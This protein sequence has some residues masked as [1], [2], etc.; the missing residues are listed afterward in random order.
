MITQR[1][2]YECPTPE[3]ATYLKNKMLGGS[4]RFEEFARRIKTDGY[5]KI[6]L[7]RFSWHVDP[8]RAK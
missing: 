2:K 8:W 1:S 4:R 3:E 6:K 7:P 5:V